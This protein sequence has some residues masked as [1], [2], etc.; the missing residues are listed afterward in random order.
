MSLLYLCLGTGL[1]DL[2][3]VDVDIDIVL[4]G[5]VFWEPA[6]G[7][8]VVEGPRR[9]DDQEGQGGAGEANVEGETD[10]LGHEADEEGN[11]LWLSAA[12]SIGNG[13]KGDIRQQHQEALYSA[14]RQ[15]AGPQSPG[16]LVSAVRSEVDGGLGA[17]YDLALDGIAHLLEELVG[18]V[19]CRG[20]G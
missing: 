20:L 12:R 7:I 10:I 15:A 9:Y 3:P 13:E 19:E 18:H 5:V 17:T 6:F 1:S 4:C 8:L 14:C 11:N 2:V 16:I